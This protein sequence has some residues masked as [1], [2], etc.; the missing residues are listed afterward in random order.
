MFIDK[1]NSLGDEV[2][3]IFPNVN[4]I[5]N[6]DKV[7]KLGG[8]EVYVRGLG[9]MSKRD[10]SGKYYIYKK[11]K[12]FKENEVI[13]DKLIILVMFYGSSMDVARTQRQ[14]KLK[15]KHLLPKKHPKMHQHPCIMPETAIPKQTIQKNLV[16]YSLYIYID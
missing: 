13:I 5:G 2:L 7:S 6:Q 11:S 1:F 15:N 4:I 3:G 12:A 9:P 10:E 16:R 14:Y 8:F